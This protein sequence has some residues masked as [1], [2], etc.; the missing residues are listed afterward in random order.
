MPGLEAAAG[1]L[2]ARNLQ[3]GSC[4]INEGRHVK[5]MCGSMRLEVV[6]GL[7]LLAHK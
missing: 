6:R 5:N 3:E 1:S 4:N 2:F 7:C